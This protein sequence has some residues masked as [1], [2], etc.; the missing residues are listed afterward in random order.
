MFQLNVAT[1]Q[2][3]LCL[4]AHSDDLE[5]GCGGTLRRTIQEIPRVE[6]RWHVFSASGQR[7]CEA[8]RSA[9]EFLRGGKDAQIHIGDFRESY[10]PEQWAAIKDVFETTKREFEP[11][12]IFTH[13][14]DD[15][16]QDHR[17]L[18][19]LAWNTFR[20]HTILEYEIPKY[21]GDFGN[22]NLY[23]ALDEAVCREKVAAILRHFQTQNERHWFTEDTFLALLRI[24]GIEC[25]PR[26]HYAEAFYARKLVV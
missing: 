16:H 4:G 23:V 24:R 12:V 17:V 1:V 6:I 21:D 2:R 25:G 8:E 9:K 15:R 13:W 18:S 5:I 11:D 7:R 26:T 20:N 14:R 3:V 22:P 10:F 19:D